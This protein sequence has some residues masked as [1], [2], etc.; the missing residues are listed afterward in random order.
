M[1]KCSGRNMV[2]VVQSLSP[3]RLF[4]TTW[5]A[6]CQPSL[7]FTIFWSL[8]RF[9]SIESTMPFNHLILSC[10]L[11]LLPSI[12]PIIRVFSHELALHIRQA[13]HWNFSVSLYNELSGLI[14][15][16]IDC[17]DLL[18]VQ[19]TLKSILQDH[20][21]QRYRFFSAQSSLWSNSYIHSI[22]LEKPQL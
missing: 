21:V 3:V 4:T 20:T 6:A 12:F 9:M 22:L 5:T 14:S 18:A 8:L 16:R 17:F 11:L 15:F 1:K 19:G 10:P 2:A 7:S 13:K